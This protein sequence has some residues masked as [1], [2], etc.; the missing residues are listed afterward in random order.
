MIAFDRGTHAGELAVSGGAR[1]YRRERLGLH[2]NP[3]RE[4]RRLRQGAEGE[5][6][7]A[8]HSLC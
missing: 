2:F 3:G 1:G 5:P 4:F 8:A 6:G 7:S